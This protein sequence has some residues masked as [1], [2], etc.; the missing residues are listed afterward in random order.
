MHAKS[1]SVIFAQAGFDGLRIGVHWL[2]RVKLR[3][4]QE[5]RCLGVTFGT[6]MNCVPHAI[7][8]SIEVVPASK[9][10]KYI[11][12]SD[13]PEDEILTAVITPTAFLRT[14][15]GSAD[16]LP[17]FFRAAGASACMLCSPGSYSESTGVY[18]VAF[19]Y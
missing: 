7:K 16:A 3:L 8:W 5:S 11:P 2:R 1:R 4:H 17:I 13:S 18:F 14:W 19:N 6:V 15:R 12:N 9:Y 10:S